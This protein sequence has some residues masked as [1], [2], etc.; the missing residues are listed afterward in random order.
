MGEIEKMLVSLFKGTVE[1]FPDRPT[2]IG[3]RVIP[4]A[5]RRVSN[6]CALLGQSPYTGC[7]LKCPL[8]KKLKQG[9]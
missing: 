2:E 1:T 5:A 4:C 7:C 9:G 8:E 6:K 3:E